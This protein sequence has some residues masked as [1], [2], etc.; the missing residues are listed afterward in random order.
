MSHLAA[1]A[2]RP[3]D[4]R[5]Q[6]HAITPANTHAPV[7]VDQRTR[8][9]SRERRT[10]AR[11]TGDRRGAQRHAW[12][13]NAA[14][15][16]V[17]SEQALKRLAFTPAGAPFR[18]VVTPNVDHLVRLEREPELARLYA[19]ADLSVCD[20]RVLQALGRFGNT[21][22]DATPGADLAAAL[23]ETEIDPN[24]TVTII[25]SNDAQVAALKA[26]FGLTDVRCHQPPFGLKSKPDAIAACAAFVAA[27]PSRFV[28]LCV[29]SP[30]QELVAEACAN[31]GDCVGW[32]LCV[33]AS[34]DFLT[35]E[36]ARAP[37]W[38]RAL[39]A[40]WLHRLASEPA[41]LWRR[42][43]VDGPKIFVLWLVWR[44]RQARINALARELAARANTRANARTGAR[45]G[46]AL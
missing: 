15:D 8:S 17:T 23:F 7:R 32:G 9:A 41:R 11:A 44:H 16:Q 3:A 5:P 28:F 6:T 14:F 26:K 45:T 12:M 10:T 43:L 27:N 24:E 13:M 19:Q 46:A 4:P 35:G 42:Y 30:Q 37:K 20:S 22:M 34:L 25:G 36:V 18:F 2:P 29:G 40:E 39:G 38:M 21:P 1:A 31:R 33:G